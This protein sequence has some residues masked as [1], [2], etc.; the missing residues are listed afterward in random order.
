MGRGRGLRFSSGPDPR[1][2][3]RG[4]RRGGGIKIIRVSGAFMNS[5]FHSEQVQYTQLGGYLLLPFITNEKYGGSLAKAQL[6][7]QRHPSK[8][9]CNTQGNI[10]MT[11]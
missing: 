5:P 3:C 11:T 4:S 1:G 6:N 7:E 9:Q 2:V 10:N 8:Q